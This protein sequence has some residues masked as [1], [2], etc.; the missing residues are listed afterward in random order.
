MNSFSF[1]EGNVVKE[2][3]DEVAFRKTGLEYWDVVGLA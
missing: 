1:K 2:M 3:E